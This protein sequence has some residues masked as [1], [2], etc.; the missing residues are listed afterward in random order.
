MQENALEVTHNRLSARE[1]LVYG[2]FFTPCMCISRYEM[3]SAKWICGAMIQEEEEE[4]EN[5]REEEG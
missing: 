2:S 4:E 3:S 5:L 1:S